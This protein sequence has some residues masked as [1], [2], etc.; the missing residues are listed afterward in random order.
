LREQVYDGPWEVLVVNNRS[1]DAT[2]DVVKAYQ[3][4][5]PNLRLVQALDKQ[6]CSYASNVGARAADG[7]ALIFCDA[8]D[9]AAPGWL[10]ALAAAL[11]NHEVVAGLI[12]IDTLNPH[13]P[14]R[15]N[16]IVN[17]K[18]P[19]LNFLP[20]APGT[21]LALSRAAFEA[22][23]GFTEDIPPCEDIDI[24]WRLQ[25]KGYTIEDAPDAVMHIRYRETMESLW[26]QVTSY[27]E[28]HVFLY[29]RFAQHGM[30]R[31]SMRDVARRYYWLLANVP[32]LLHPNRQERSKWV[33]Q[34]AGRWGRLRGSLRYRTLYL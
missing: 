28:C 32:R 17:S 11:E 30:P 31:S 14:W 22:V 15:P 4:S 33:Y 9:V 26:K 21:N 20:Q 5:M 18:Q 34:A 7:D 12:E 2:V 16:P 27:G 8:D 29:Q 23:G 25:L 3:A 24:S 10:A 13:A 6:G 1:T 19:A